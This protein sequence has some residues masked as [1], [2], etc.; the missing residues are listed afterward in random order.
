MAMPLVNPMTTMRGMN[1]T[2]APRPV[3]PMSISRMP[4]ISV[5]M[6][7]PLMPKRSDNARDDHDECAGWT[8][9]LGA[10]SAQRGDQ[11]TGHDR[12]INSRL[13]SDPG[14][15]AKGH[16]QRQRDQTHGD[17]R[18]GGRAGTSETNRHGMPKSIWGDSDCLWTLDVSI[19]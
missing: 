8:A 19:F 7:S 5:T 12:G 18:P 11:E 16:G 13:R 1:R 15:D 9:D 14:S 2:A 10:R 6:A 17:A 4:A 3:S